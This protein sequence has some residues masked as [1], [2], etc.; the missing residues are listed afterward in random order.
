VS[1]LEGMKEGFTEGYRITKEKIAESSSLLKSK[2][3][4]KKRSCWGGSYHIVSKQRVFTESLSIRERRGGNDLIGVK[5]LVHSNKRTRLYSDRRKK[6][7][8]GSHSWR[9]FD[10]RIPD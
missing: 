8:Q 1:K 4:E 7:T 5:L 9:S 2:G 6:G 3:A 10:K